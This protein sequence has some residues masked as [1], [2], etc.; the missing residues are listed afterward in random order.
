MFVEIIGHFAEQFIWL[1]RLKYF[2]SKT[3]I[4]YTY[5]CAETNRK[6]LD[7]IYCHHKQIKLDHKTTKGS[8]ERRVLDVTDISN[9]IPCILVG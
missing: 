3:K 4:K 9:S 6:A 5:F 8:K 1:G 2:S 7:Y